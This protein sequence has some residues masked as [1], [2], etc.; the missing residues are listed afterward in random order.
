[1]ALQLATTLA[2]LALLTF[3]EGEH[4]EPFGDLAIVLAAMYTLRLVS[5]IL[6]RE[7]GPSVSEAA[8]DLR[9]GELGAILPLLGILLAL[10]AWPAGISEH[11]SSGNVTVTSV[12]AGTETEGLLRARIS[13][14][15]TEMTWSTDSPRKARASTRPRQRF[16]PVP[17]V[18]SAAIAMCSGRAETTTGAPTAK[19]PSDRTRRSPLSV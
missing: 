19:S 13:R 7:P 18:V 2:V 4:R 12:G 10:S 11:A 15:P 14:E 1:M 5:A 6:H 9:P 8:L 3:A 17:F 16:G